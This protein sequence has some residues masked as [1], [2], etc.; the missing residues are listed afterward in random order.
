MGDLLFGTTIHLHVEY[1]INL[2]DNKIIQ[3]TLSYSSSHC[4]LPAAFHQ[5][6]SPP[7]VINVRH[8]PLYNT[9]NMCYPV[10]GDDEMSL[11]RSSRVGGAGGP[12][13]VDV[14]SASLTV[15]R[16]W[17]AHPQGTAR[18]TARRTVSP[19][20]HGLR[21]ATGAWGLG[22]GAWGLGPGAWGLGPGAWG[23]ASVWVDFPTVPSV[24]STCASLL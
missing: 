20:P 8:V 10:C 7:V 21:T 19:T 11:L 24:Q 15:Y 3:L 4:I 22:P 18:R 9:L 23:V 6:H 12:S 14:R 13:V 2:F 5:S 17:R 1:R 16:A